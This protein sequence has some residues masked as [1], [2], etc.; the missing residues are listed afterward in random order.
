MSNQSSNQN[1][2]ETQSTPSTPTMT[3]QEMEAEFQLPIDHL[4]QTDPLNLE[5]QDLVSLVSHYRSQRLN[6]QKL[7]EKPKTVERSRNPKLDAEASKA[8]LDAILAG[9]VGKKKGD[10]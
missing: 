1:P 2:T 7:E 10:E 5:E 3:I 8:K 9:M 6:F 4:F